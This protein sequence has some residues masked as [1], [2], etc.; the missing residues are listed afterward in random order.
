MTHR[1][2][3]RRPSTARPVRDRR[4]T[5]DQPTGWLALQRTAGNRAVTH[6]LQHAPDG[7][8]PKAATPDQPRVAAAPVQRGF[9]K[10][11]KKGLKK[12]GSGIK[13]GFK[14]VGS[15][16]K[17]GAKAVGKAFKKLGRGIKKGAKAVW[18]GIKWTSKQLWTKLKGI[19][20]RAVRWAKKLPTRLRRL[21]SHL[22][23]GVKALKPW[24][25]KW[26]RSLG[27][28]GTWK[29]FGRWLGNLVIY[30]LE[31]LGIG[32]IYETIADFI[33]F[34]TREL[35]GAEKA[36]ARRVFGSAIPLSLVRVDS[37]AVI[38]PA[39]TKREYVSFHTINGWG[40][41]NDHTLIHELTHVWQYESM[42][43]RYMPKAIHAQA[44]MGDA[45]YQYGGL[46]GLEA[47]RAAGKPLTSFTM[48]QQGDILGDYYVLR[49]QN[50]AA[51]DSPAV[52]TYAHF[53]DQVKR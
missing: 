22:W 45:A 28:A 42:G 3:T 50:G 47:A 33:K 30:G 12:I 39:F 10:K 18:T 43:A 35:T 31:T 17:K 27:K 52:E 21:V 13:K 9:W 34:N 26:W 8:G 46:T 1:M 24:S 23:R 2:R 16:I 36:K 38:G 25:L 14:K 7:I 40:T 29:S 5:N 53:A 20:L 15:G 19:G 44:T 6:A 11:L 37:R 51:P 4:G 49:F 41:M 32:E 48:E